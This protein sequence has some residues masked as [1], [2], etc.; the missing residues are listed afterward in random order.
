MYLESTSSSSSAAE[1]ELEI[2]VGRSEAS[3]RK[4]SSLW[5]H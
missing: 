3:R 4:I 2:E 1:A 5:Q